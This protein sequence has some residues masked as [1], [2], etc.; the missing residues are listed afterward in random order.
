MAQ[1]LSAGAEGAAAGGRRRRPKTWHVLLAVGL[2]SIIAGVALVVGPLLSIWGRG[3]ADKTALNNWNAALTGPAK[4]A[5]NAVKTACGS[6]SP[7]DYALV[8]FSG[9]AQ[10]H[11]AGVSGDGTWDPLHDRT[12]VHYHGTP[13]PGQ[14][15]N[16][17]IA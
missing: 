8:S 13:D 17:I 12:M 10:N 14:Q 6:A 4:D 15:G 1:E 2:A 3:Q 11:Y 16:S 7:D 9:P 5:G